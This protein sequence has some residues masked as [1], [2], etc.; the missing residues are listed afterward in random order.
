MCYFAL[1][2]VVGVVSLFFNW[3]LRTF[4]SIVN[5]IR[6][7]KSSAPPPPP[8]SCPNAFNFGATLLCDGEFPKQIVLHRVAKHF[9]WIA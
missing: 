8:N 3:T 5:S 2:M 7:V 4:I 6:S 9:F 1:H